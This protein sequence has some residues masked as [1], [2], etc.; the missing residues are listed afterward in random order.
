MSEIVYDLPHL[1]KTE[2]KFV[3]D[4]LLLILYGKY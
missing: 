1:L 4:F 2:E 3:S